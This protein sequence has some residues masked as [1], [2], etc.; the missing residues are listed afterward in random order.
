MNRAALSALLRSRR[1]GLRPAD[2]GL[3]AEGRR[4]TPGLR[5]D[6]VAALAGLPLSFYVRLEQGRGAPPSPERL[7]ALASVLRLDRDGF[8]ELARLAGVPQ[9]E[10]ARSYLEPGL[11]FLL[12]ALS[13]VPAWVQDEATTVVACNA[14][15]E[16]VFGPLPEPSDPR[17]NS[18]WQWFV[19][20]HLRRLIRAEDQDAISLSLVA[21]LRAAAAWTTG[22]DNRVNRLVADMR[23]QSPLFARLWDGEA[24]TTFAPIHLRVDHPQQGTFGV[25]CDVLHFWTGHTVK[26]LRPDLGTQMAERLARLK[27]LRTEAEHGAGADRPR[28][29]RLGL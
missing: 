5:R 12:D 11:M 18:S 21:E 6:E 13:D 20:P 3:P 10:T 27:R 17:A 15:C 26:F 7:A 14:T 25:T 23:A 4:R 9:V 19:E 24:V 29:N 8:A 28:S 2:V 1:E 16:A 22:V